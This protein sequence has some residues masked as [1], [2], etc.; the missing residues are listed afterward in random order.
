MTLKQLLLFGIGRS[1]HQRAY[2]IPQLQL[3]L[4]RRCAID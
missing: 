3:K 1:H 2:D 4:R